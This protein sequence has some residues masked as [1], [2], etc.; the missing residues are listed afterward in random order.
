MFDEPVFFQSDPGYLFVPSGARAFDEQNVIKKYFPNKMKRYE[1]GFN[2]FQS[3]DTDL[4][5]TDLPENVLEL[6]S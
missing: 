5:E 3:A 4:L 6:K 1:A 2:I